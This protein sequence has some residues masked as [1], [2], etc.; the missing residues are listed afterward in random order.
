M[1][2]GRNRRRRNSCA[3]A[4]EEKR[5]VERGGRW[6]DCPLAP[7]EPLL[8]SI[9]PPLIPHNRSR[10]SAHVACSTRV[11]AS[12]SPQ[13]LTCLEDHIRRHPATLRSPTRPPT[14][15]HLPIT[16]GNDPTSRKHSLKQ[17]TTSNSHNSHQDHRDRDKHLRLPSRRL[18]GMYG[19]P[20]SCK[21]KVEMRGL[22]CANVSGLM[23]SRGSGPRWNALRSRPA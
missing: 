16:I 14:T 2:G 21:R 19:P 15:H 10:Q 12:V 20:P 13:H 8:T 3:G 11:F 22:V 4:A 9:W 6:K 1:P 18:L 17:E 7:S 23:L 5:R